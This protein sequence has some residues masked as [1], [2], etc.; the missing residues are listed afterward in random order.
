MS[1]V[2]GKSASAGTSTKAGN[3]RM[4]WLLVEAAWT[5]LRSKS[6]ETAALR[7]WT[8]QIAQRRGKRIAVVA[9]ARRLAGILYAMWRTVWPTMRSS[10]ERARTGHHRAPRNGGGP[11]RESR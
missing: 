4:R 1:A 9:L 6:P 11:M 5:I 10:F 8:V 7:A 3:G 2:Q